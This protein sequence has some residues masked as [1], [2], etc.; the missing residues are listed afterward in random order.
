MLL[1]SIYAINIQLPTRFPDISRLEAATRMLR[2]SD[3][4]LNVER[5]LFYFCSYFTVHWKKRLHDLR[6]GFFFFV[7]PFCFTVIWVWSL[8]IGCLLCASCCNCSFLP[9]IKLY[10]SLFNK[11]CRIASTCESFKCECTIKANARSRLWWRKLSHSIG[12][13]WSTALLSKP[14]CYSMT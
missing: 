5:C 6:L 14:K 7:P 13:F 3:W 4:P 1:Y 9:I 12:C 11:T 8:H 2:D 10:L